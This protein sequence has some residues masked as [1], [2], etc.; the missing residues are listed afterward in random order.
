MEDKKS[1]LRV[2]GS[3]SDNPFTKARNFINK[4]KNESAIDDVEY[5]HVLSALICTDRSI[6][7]LLQKWEY[8]NKN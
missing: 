1:R 3:S 5:L 6:D 8:R 2:L 4:K 7:Q